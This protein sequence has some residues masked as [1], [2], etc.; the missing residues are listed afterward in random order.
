M[1]LLGQKS[2]PQHGNALYSITACLDLILI[3]NRYESQEYYIS[4]KAHVEYTGPRMK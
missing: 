1:K 4:A 2:N 3:P